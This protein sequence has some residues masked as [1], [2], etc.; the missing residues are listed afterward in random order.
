MEHTENF[1]LIKVG[2]T[3][4][5]QQ[6]EQ[7]A[8]FCID[9]RTQPDEYSDRVE[10]SVSK[11]NHISNRTNF[12]FTLADQRFHRREVGVLA[13]RQFSIYSVADPGCS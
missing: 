3:D 5:V 9:T 8:L 13:R 10:E 4:L 6:S 12:T 2:E 11:Y 1:R 7:L